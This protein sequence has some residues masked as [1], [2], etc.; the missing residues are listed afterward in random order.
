MPALKDISMTVGDDFSLTIPD[1]VDM[2]GDGIKITSI[3]FS[4]TPAFI[5]GTYPTYSLSP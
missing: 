4:P 2:D 1:P 3:K 5:S